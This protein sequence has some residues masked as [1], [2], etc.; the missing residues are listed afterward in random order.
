MVCNNRRANEGRAGVPVFQT[1]A[2]TSQDEDMQKGSEC[3]G[4]H[5]LAPAISGEMAVRT[6]LSNKESQLAVPH[7][8]NP[9]R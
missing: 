9:V 6:C 5:I 3:Y 4:C 7:N 1:W 2:K 8:C